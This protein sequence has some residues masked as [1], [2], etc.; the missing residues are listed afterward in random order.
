MLV[1]SMQQYVELVY[2]VLTQQFQEKE[3]L[4]NICLLLA[5]ECIMVYAYV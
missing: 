3:N 1:I 5:C 2:H 4:Y